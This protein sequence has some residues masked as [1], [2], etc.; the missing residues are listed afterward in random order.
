[1]TIR[2]DQNDSDFQRVREF[3]RAWDAIGLYHPIDV[4]DDDCPPDEYDSYI[5]HILS[6]LR[7]G[8]GA[9]RIASHLEFARTQ[10]MGL[11][12]HP[13]RDLEFGRR[14]EEWWRSERDR[15]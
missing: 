7:S 15:A 9:D 2:K 10:Q 4:E 12:P 11:P 5:P 14:I 8:H 13:S 1:M 6:L 3:L